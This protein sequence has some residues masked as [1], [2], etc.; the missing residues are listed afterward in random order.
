MRVPLAGHWN[1]FLQKKKA[2]DSRKPKL[3]S[4]PAPPHHL[5]FPVPVYRPLPAGT[6]EGGR[7]L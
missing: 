1:N 4:S 7:G 2:L 5:H 6:P 3:R